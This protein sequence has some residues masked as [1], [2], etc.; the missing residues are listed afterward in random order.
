MNPLLGKTTPEQFWGHCCS[1]GGQPAPLHPLP[2]TSQKRAG[3][4]GAAPTTGELLLPSL[5]VL[6]SCQMKRRGSQWM[7]LGRG[8]GGCWR[9]TFVKKRGGKART[10]RL[11]LALHSGR[12]GDLLSGSDEE[13]CTGVLFSKL[14]QT[15]L[16]VLGHSRLPLGKLCY[17]ARKR[18]SELAGAQS[19]SRV[20]AV[21]P[22]SSE[23]P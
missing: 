9:F 12:V 5:P 1:R 18:G 23:Q 8:G 11:K 21:L 20:K 19:F 10:L 22:K 6:L 15:A 13:I 3:E 16:R 7:G 4:R 2:G 14:L 17:P